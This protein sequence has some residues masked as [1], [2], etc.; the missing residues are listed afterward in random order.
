ML[1]QGGLN[2]TRHGGGSRVEGVSVLAQREHTGITTQRETHSG[3]AAYW[4]QTKAVRTG[5]EYEQGSTL[6]LLPM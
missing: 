3:V 5:T 6:E 2:R 1:V 4:A